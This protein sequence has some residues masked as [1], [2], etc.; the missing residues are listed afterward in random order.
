MA[1][2]VVF[3]GVTYSIPV[4]ADDGWGPDLTAYL[5]SIASNAFQKTGGSFT[6]TSEAN[7]GATYGVKSAYIKSQ[8]SNPSGTG[9]LRL[10]NT[11]LVSWRNAANSGDLGLTVSASDVLQFNG[12]SVVYSGSIVNADVNA[13]AAIA[14]SKMAALTASKVLV[15]DGSGIVIPSAVSSTT[16]SYLDATSS[17]QTQLDSKQ[18]TITAGTTAQYYRGDKTFQTLDK[19]AVGLANVDNTSDATKNAAAVTLTN[20]TIDAD[21]NTITNIE[22]ADI[23]AAAAIALNKLA[24]TTVSRALVSDASGFV[25]ASSV[26]STELGYVSGVTSSIQTQLNAALTNPMTTGGDIIYGGSSGAPTRLANGSSGQYLKSNGTTVAPSWATFTTPTIQKFTSG[27]GTYTPAAGVK[28]IRVIAVGGGG[29]GAGS[30]NVTFNAG[31]AGGNTTLGT[32][33]VVANGGGG[34]NSSGVGG[35]ASFS[36]SAIGIALQGAA[37]QTETNHAGNGAPGAMGGNS[38]LGGAGAGR[39]NAAGLAGVANTGSGGAGGGCAGTATFSAPGG[40][41]G[42]YVNVIIPSPSAMAYAVGAGGTVGTGSGSG[43]N[44]GA[45]GSGVIIIEEYYQ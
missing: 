33:I 6:L 8:A 11:E 45:G 13:S 9:Y 26:T 43:F 12:S 17:I 20:K 32:T 19:T 2:N 15:S 37:G 30:T 38:P 7:F 42:G 1:S 27:T 35:T 28:W 21:S 41:A 36:G 24:A 23:K 14:F 29:G 25:S 5:I 34:G 16:L 10:G 22:N 44:G 40:S 4:E 3:N 39:Y 31:A 18:P